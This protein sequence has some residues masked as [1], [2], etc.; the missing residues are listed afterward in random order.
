MVC[1]ECGALVP[2]S[3]QGIHDGWHAM[4]RNQLAVAL[5]V[6]MGDGRDESDE[7]MLRRLLREVMEL[8]QRV[9]G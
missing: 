5:S 6:A 8:S 3:E 1:S 7:E 9:Q 2:E 4:L